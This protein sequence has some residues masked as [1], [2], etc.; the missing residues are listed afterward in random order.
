MV[1]CN[2]EDVELL[3]EESSKSSPSPTITNGHVNGKCGTSQKKRN[4][5][6]VIP[7]IIDCLQGILTIIP[8]QLLSMHIADLKGHDVRPRGTT[9]TFWCCLDP[10]YL[11]RIQHTICIQIYTHPDCIFTY[12]SWSFDHAIYVSAMELLISSF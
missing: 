5:T 11:Y 3:T 2:P 12:R 8:M 1:I 6:I 9:G 10:C 4:R 7:N